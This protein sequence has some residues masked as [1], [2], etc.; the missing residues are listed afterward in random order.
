[1]QSLRNSSYGRPN[2][3]NDDPAVTATCCLPPII[4]DTAGERTGGA[5]LRLPKRLAGLE[6][7]RKAI[8]FFGATK[9]QASAV[10]N[11]P[12]N[13]GVSKLELPPQFSADRGD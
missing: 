9:N 2:T 12:V 11:K 8:T 5:K 6:I 4:N 7:E 1:V 3:N 13:E 10:D